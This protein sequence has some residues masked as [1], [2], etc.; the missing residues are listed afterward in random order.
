MEKI[1]SKASINL[2]DDIEDCLE[3]QK[4]FIIT[5]I[6]EKHTEIRRKIDGVISASIEPA[7]SH[8][9]E[10]KASHYIDKPGSITN[11]IISRIYNADLVIANL[12]G[13]N[14]NVMYE[15]AIRHAAKKPIILIMEHGDQKQPFDIYDERIIFYHDD[16]AGTLELKNNII[17]AE[18]N[19]INEELEVSNPIYDAL[20]YELREKS[21]F[22]KFEKE[23]VSDKD[24]EL[25][26]LLLSK[27]ERLESRI[28]SINN[29]KNSEVA[30]SSLSEDKVAIIGI[31]F[32]DNVSKD[33]MV[34]IK[35]DFM[36]YLLVRLNEL[37]CYS[38]EI[39][40]KEN[41]SIII[42]IHNKSEFSDRPFLSTTIRKISQSFL[43]S[44][45]KANYKGVIIEDY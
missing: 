27:I 18:K 14:P 39:K 34:N 35:R 45:E 5:P 44:N 30:T 38:E 11:E 28:D 16:I 22:Q 31:D 17:K 43:D 36:R 41:D 21:L 26:K 13:L 10:I 8:K 24:I 42:K 6:G 33:E 25:V 7:L 23:N 9:Y 40:N 2:K 29:I 37:K 12:T 32:K 4:C 15:I 3:L 19:L 1:K 20:Q